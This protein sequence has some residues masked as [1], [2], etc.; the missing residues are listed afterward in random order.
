MPSLLPIAARTIL[1][2]AVTAVLL[3]AAPVD[4]AAIFRAFDRG[5]YSRAATLL[6]QA[7]EERPG[8][9]AGLYYNLACARSRLGQKQAATDALMRAVRAGF[10][11]FDHMRGDP[12]LEAIR[13]ER[14][15]L[16]IVEAAGRTE[17]K[18]GGRALERWKSTFGVDE[19]RY[20]FDD[21]RRFVYATTLDDESQRAVRDEI[22]MQA[23]LLG[24]MLFGEPAT[25]YV[26]VAVPTTEH[27]DRIFGGDPSIAGQY[28]HID[29]QLVVRDVGL[30]LRHEL[31]HALHYGHMERLALRESHPI[32]IVEGLATL[33]ETYELDD[34]GNPVF[35]PNDRHNVAYRVVKAGRAMDWKKLAGLRGEPFM[36]KAGQL[37]P[38]VR[39][40]FEFIADNGHLET[41][42]ATYIRTFDQDPS[43]H[44]ALEEA[45]G[46]PIGEIEQSWKEWVLDRGLVDIRVDRGDASLGIQ[47]RPHDS[48]DGVLVGRVLP[49]SGAR[50][51][52]IRA[53]D[54]IVSIDGAR[55]PSL[56]ELRGVVSRL[57]VGDEVDVRARRR[58]EYMTFRV[59]LSPRQ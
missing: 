18:R 2:I 50:E 4:D 19:Y 27:A 33:F 43:G 54:V 35:L 55:T 3:G 37:Y 16:A 23:D 13:G 47:A 49:N 41:W 11:Q 44:T 36:R 48:A 58:D 8:D 42:Y 25:Y 20:E 22:E 28:Q 29:R 53:G 15:Y 34:D 12:D 32:W 38:I 59:V 51:A 10:R 6:E 24:R 7:I 5:Q 17:R 14:V 1:L 46:R 45:F 30:S 39:S 56:M 21:E 57:E 31:V 26:L 9:A 52:G 40:I